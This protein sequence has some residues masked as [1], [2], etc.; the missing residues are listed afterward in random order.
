M[1][2]KNPI[3]RVLVIIGIA[4]YIGMVGG[5]AYALFEDLYKG[6]EYRSPYEYF[7]R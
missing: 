7:E 1:N 4:L 2:M 5:M 6:I 3:I